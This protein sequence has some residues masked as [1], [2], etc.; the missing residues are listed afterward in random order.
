MDPYDLALRLLSLQ[1]SSTAAILQTIKGIIKMCIRDRWEMPVVLAGMYGLRM[2]EINN[3]Q[4]RW[5]IP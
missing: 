2:S 5:C 4:G 3:N 1:S